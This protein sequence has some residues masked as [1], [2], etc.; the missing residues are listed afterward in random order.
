MNLSLLW[1]NQITNRSSGF[2]RACFPVLDRLLVRGAR[3]KGISTLQP[4]VFVH[5]DCHT[6]NILHRCAGLVFCDWQSWGNGRPSSDL[7]FLSVR[8]V[9]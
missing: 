8:A 4:G 3:F 1:I 2:G 5:G 6:D 9:P 7:A